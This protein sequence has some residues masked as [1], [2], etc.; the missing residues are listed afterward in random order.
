MTEGVA[1]GCG[2]ALWALTKLK[3]HS[4]AAHCLLRV[5]SCWRCHVI[6]VRALVQAV[7][8]ALFQFA[9]TTLYTYETRARFVSFVYSTIAHCSLIDWSMFFFLQSTIYSEF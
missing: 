4:L 5:G 1:C 9:L 3:L 8:V 2:C 7:R 6:L